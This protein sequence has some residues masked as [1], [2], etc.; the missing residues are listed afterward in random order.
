MLETKDKLLLNKCERQHSA[1]S[2][3]KWSGE[4]N[5]F[6]S[7]LRKWSLAKRKGN[8]AGFHIL[9]NIIKLSESPEVEVSLYMHK[10]EIK[11]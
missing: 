8:T 11:S 4:E 2:L 10:S 3:G 9:C 6:L 5:N 7:D 1:V